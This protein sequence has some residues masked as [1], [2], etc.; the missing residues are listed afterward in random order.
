MSI[1]RTRV[2]RLW[3]AAAFVLALG[4]AGVAQAPVAPVPV[5]QA[6]ALALTAAMPVDAAIARGQLPNGLRYYVRANPKPEK[7]AE[8]RLVVQ[9]GSI[10]E[11]DDQQGL[12]HV[13]EHMAFNGSTHFPKQ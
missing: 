4:R 6:R 3:I 9:A 1:L 8:L 13:V 2:S 10:L 11:E 7:R 5:S 12:A